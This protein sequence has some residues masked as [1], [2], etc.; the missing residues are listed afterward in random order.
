MHANLKWISVFRSDEISFG[1]ELM[2]TDWAAPKKKVS[3]RNTS[4]VIQM[5]DIELCKFVFEILR[6]P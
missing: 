3:F 2:L 6:N 5:K 1:Q 4:L